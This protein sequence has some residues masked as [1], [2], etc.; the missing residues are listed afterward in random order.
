LQ[1]LAEELEVNSKRIEYAL[2]LL[3]GQGAGRKRWIVLPK[4]HAPS[5]L[6]VAILLY[7]PSDRSLNLFIDCKNELEPAGHTENRRK[8]TGCATSPR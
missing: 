8:R 1:K 6:R 5:T 4:D 2:N 7:E 3:V